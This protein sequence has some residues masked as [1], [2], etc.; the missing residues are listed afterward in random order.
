[1]KTL[2]AL[3]MGIFLFGTSVSVAS[4]PGAKQDAKMADL[5]KIQVKSN[6]GEAVPMSTYQGKVLLVVNTASKCGYT[7]QYAGLQTIYQR[8]QGKGF[9]VLA[10]PSNDFGQQEPGDS[11]QIKEFC[12]LKYKTKFPLFEKAPVTGS[13][14]QPIF[15][16]LVKGGDEV[17]W[18]FEKFLISKS[19]LV[20]GRYKSG[21]APESPEIVQ[22]IEAELAK[23]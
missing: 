7:P 5:Y 6:A 18:N 3:V 4:K 16:F 8:Y 19:G 23:K 12:E 10:F 17:A 11:K 22:A 2:A 9:E 1:M 21:V 20:V 14:K 15:E 13:K